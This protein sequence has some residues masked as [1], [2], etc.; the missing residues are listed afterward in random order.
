LVEGA[1][2]LLMGKKKR[3]GHNPPLAGLGKGERGERLPT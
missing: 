2:F 1:R 3:E